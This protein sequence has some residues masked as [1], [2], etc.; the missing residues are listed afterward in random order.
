MLLRRSW[1]S[2]WC[3]WAWWVRSASTSWKRR[4]LRWSRTL[5]SSRTSPGADWIW[6]SKEQRR[7]CRWDKKQEYTYWLTR[8]WEY[9]SAGTYVTLPAD[10]SLPEPPVCQC[11][12]P[13]AAGWWWHLSL[14]GC[15]SA[16]P[17]SPAAASGR[18]SRHHT[19]APAPEPYP[20]AVLPG[21]DTDTNIPIRKQDEAT[22]CQE[23]KMSLFCV[24]SYSDGLL[25]A[26][27][28]AALSL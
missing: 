18:S 17:H 5:S 4:S 16:S 25:I 11:A 27:Q 20:A 2:F 8:S 13:S 12:V 28:D 26:G 7:S 9:F 24:S 3:S 19:P 22:Y 14:S 23:K 15:S 21:S 10:L 6:A 1:T